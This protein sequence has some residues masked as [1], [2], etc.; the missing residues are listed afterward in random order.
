VHS[1]PKGWEI[2]TIGKKLKIGVPVKSGDIN[3]TEFLRVAYDHSTNKT[4]ATGFCIDVFTAVVEILP[5][6]LPYEFVRYAKPDG[7]EMAGTYDELINQL[8]YGVGTPFLFYILK[9]PLIYVSDS[10][11][12]ISMCEQLQHISHTIQ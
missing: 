5:Y 7:D 1:I 11:I 12:M 9:N 6:D 2:P 8:Y 3:Y 10:F 4:Q